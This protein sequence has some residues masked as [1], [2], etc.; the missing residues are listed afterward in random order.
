MALAALLA[1]TL[2]AGDP[3]APSQSPGLRGAESQGANGQNTPIATAPDRTITIQADPAPAAADADG[4]QDIPPGAP[5]DDYGFVA[6]CYGAMDESI[7]VYQQVLPELK[8]I[9]ARIGSPVKEA[10]PYAQDVAEERIALKRFAAAMEAAERAS[11]GPSPNWAPRTSIRAA[12]SG[13]R[14]SCKP[15]RQLAHAWLMW[16]SPDRC[17]TAAQD[18]KGPRHPAGPG[19]GDRRANRRRAAAARR[20]GGRAGQRAVHDRFDS[21][22]RTLRQDRPSATCSLAGDDK[23]LAKLDHPSGNWDQRLFKPKP[24]QLL[25][26]SPVTLDALRPRL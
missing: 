15:S 2:V 18:V 7:L 10:V 11:P 14:P 8:A 21:R 19:D 17:E 5:R 20:T 16:G 1:L 6:W 4:D 26:T 13:P 23:A 3:S 22:R 25:T 9:D 12:R 24:F